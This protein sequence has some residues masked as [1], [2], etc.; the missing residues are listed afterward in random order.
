MFEEQDIIRYLQAAPKAFFSARDIC[1]RAGGKK[2]F[3]GQP[4]WA[5]PLLPRLVEKGIIETDAA[6]HFRIKQLQKD[7]RP[8]KRRWVSPQM[9]KLLKE[10]GKDFGGEITYDLEADPE[11]ETD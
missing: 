6:G 5:R 3:R 9:A 7:E 8:V 10:S 4:Y 1:R 11:T 2:I